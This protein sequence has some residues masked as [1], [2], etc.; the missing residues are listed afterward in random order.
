MASSSLTAQQKMDAWHNRTRGL[1]IS[2][3]GDDKLINYY[4]DSLLGPSIRATFYK[5]NVEL[6][7]M[8]SGRYFTE[9]EIKAVTD[10]VVV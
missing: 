2:A 9:E 3:C 1:N 6:P 7:E 10:T 8:T 4:Y 5:G